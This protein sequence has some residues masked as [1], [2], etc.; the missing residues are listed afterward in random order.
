MSVNYSSAI[1]PYQ[2]PHGHHRRGS[3]SPLRRAVM[4][5][6]PACCAARRAERIA[7]HL[8]RGA[9]PVRPCG[10]MWKKFSL[11]FVPGVEYCGMTD[12]FTG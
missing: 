6:R 3:D 8:P 4:L 1:E 10:R 2:R 9:A 5:F 12:Y 7:R 11:F